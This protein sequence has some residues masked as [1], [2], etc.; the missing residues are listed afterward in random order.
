MSAAHTGLSK[1][2]WS[3]SNFDHHS[4]TKWHFVDLMLFV[5]FHEGWVLSDALLARLL[6]T[7]SV[8]CHSLHG[9]V[10][11]HGGG[12]V[13]PP[14]EGGSAEKRRAVVFSGV[15]TSRIRGELKT[16]SV[17]PY[18]AA[19]NS[20]GAVA[21]DLCTSRWNHDTAKERSSRLGG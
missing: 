9:P 3:H 18:H 1:S 12:P 11:V 16:R 2:S 21:E 4:I 17:G 14:G 7:V 19:W 10:L 6:A 15:P 13:K 8:R 20:A 5:P